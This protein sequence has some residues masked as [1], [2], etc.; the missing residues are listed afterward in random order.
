VPIKQVTV[1]GDFRF[2]DKAQVEEIMLPHLARA[3][4]WSTWR[5]SANDLKRLA[6][7]A[8]R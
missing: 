5:E 3:I 2:L 6:D 1:N 4:S 7:G 8:A